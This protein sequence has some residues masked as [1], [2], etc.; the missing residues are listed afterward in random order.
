MASRVI[1]GAV[2][3]PIVMV[4][5]WA[6]LPWLSLLA[7]ILA[8]LGALE[9]YRL[10]ERREAR[11]AVLLGIAWTLAFIVSGHRDDWP[12]PWIALGGAAVV[13]SWHQLRRLAG[14]PFLERVFSKVGIT[15][16]GFND[17]LVDW[18]YTAAGAIY[19]GWTLSLFLVLRREIDGLEWVLVAILGTFAT[20]I[21]ALVTGKA[22]GRRLLVP[23]IS[24]GK[25]WEGAIGGFLLGAGV[26]LALTS[27]LELSVSVWRGVV[28][29]VLVGISA[30]VGDLVESMIKR[31]S[32]VKDAGSIIP[33]HGGI[34]DRL[35][36]VVFV[37]LVVYH[38]S[39]WTVK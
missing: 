20:D 28:L 18:V 11:P 24:P 35:D 30:Q 7:A 29:G 9:F 38:F 12:A 23:H 1:S 26:V 15:S 22:L 19:I 5:V 36:S 32:G 16:R 34:L 10:A 31:A 25:T 21:G 2:G 39:I 17:A 13:F 6:G 33:G 3:I 8:S 37:I 4:A 27:W 14:L